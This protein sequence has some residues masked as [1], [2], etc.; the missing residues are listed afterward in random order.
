MQNKILLAVL[1]TS[2]ER[3]P[4]ETPLLVASKMAQGSRLTLKAAVFLGNELYICLEAQPFD[5]I[6]LFR[7]RLESANGVREVRVSPVKQAA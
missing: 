7:T 2:L 1:C 4:G 3:K 6:E 5:E